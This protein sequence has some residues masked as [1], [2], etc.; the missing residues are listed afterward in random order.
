MISL[1]IVKKHLN[2]E[3]DYTI[4]DEYLFGLIEAA[5]TVVRKDLTIRCESEMYDEEGEIKP[6]IKHAA[7]CSHTCSGKYQSMGHYSFNS[8][9]Y[10]SYCKLNSYKIDPAEYRKLKSVK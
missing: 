4:D 5:E 9:K 6:D 10:L 1:D 2:I 8:N 7:C 3:P